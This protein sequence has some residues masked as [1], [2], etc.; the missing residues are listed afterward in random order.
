MNFLRAPL[1]SALA[2][3]ALACMCTK[4]AFA[5][6]RGYDIWFSGRVLSVDQH[7]DS[8]RVARGPTETAAPG[9]ENCVVR[10][11]ALQVLRPGMEIEAE[12]DTRRRPW[13][14]LHLHIFEI[15]KHRPVPVEHRSSA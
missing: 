7:H 10:Q 3:A 13:N 8:L 1:R 9:V 2:F 14:I 11:R 12:A 15:V 6:D 5:S 4:P